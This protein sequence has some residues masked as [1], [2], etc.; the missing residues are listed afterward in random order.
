MNA[1]EAAMVEIL[2][3]RFRNI[4]MTPLRVVRNDRGQCRLVY[5][6]PSYGLVARAICSDADGDDESHFYVSH[7]PARDEAQ[8][9][10]AYAKEAA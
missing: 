9:L 4:G 3:E 1:A 8:L 2:V 10:V 6:S 7:D 5:H